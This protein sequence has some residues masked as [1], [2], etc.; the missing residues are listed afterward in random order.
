MEN[1]LSVMTFNVFGGYEFREARCPHIVQEVLKFQ[2]DIICLQEATL[3]ITDGIKQ[4]GLH[5]N[6]ELESLLKYKLV[7]SKTQALL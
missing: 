5:Q 3:D 7:Y 4:K 2:P 6:N 1:T